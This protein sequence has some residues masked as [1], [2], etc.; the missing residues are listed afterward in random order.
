VAQTIKTGLID[1]ED[2]LSNERVI[3]MSEKVYKAQP[4][5]TQFTTMLMMLSSKK[6]TREVI[7]WLEEQYRQRTSSLTASATSAATSIE[8]TG[9]EGNTVFATHDVVRNQETGE[10]YVVNGVTSA[11]AIPIS[12]SWGGTAAASSTSAAKLMIV[13]NAYPQGASSG[14]VRYV[15]RTRGFNY[16]QEFREPIHFTFVQEAIELYGGGEPEKELVRAAINHKRGVEAALFW[17]AR[18]QD[19]A[20]SPGPRGGMGGAFEFI[21]TN[22]TDAGGA[23]TPLEW[24]TFFETVLA[25]SED[26]VLFAAPRVATTI[27]QMYRGSWQSNTDGV[28]KWGVKVNG[29]LDST[30]GRNI[31]I[32]V[33]KE[34]SD[35]ST[36]ADNYGTW[37]FLIDMAAV[38]LRPL[39]GYTVG[40]V[41]RNI[42][43][44]SATANVHEYYS[45]VSLE[46]AAEARHAIIKDVSSYAAS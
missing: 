39:M 33:K 34:W 2:V 16:I 27:S 24:D 10:A 1:T 4:D 9:G 13:G 42:G 18:D 6:A 36:A 41:R 40:T 8:V 45:P 29:F 35:L 46:F 32:I 7:D 14:T 31:P 3:D 21:T 37:A 43:E 5:S 30:Y 44:P 17:G 38:R 11:S 25:N 15:Q 26:P 28:Q 20:A 23:T 22:V 12:R 19:T